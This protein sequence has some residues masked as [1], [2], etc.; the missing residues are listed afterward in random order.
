MHVPDGL[1]APPVYAAAAAIA[2]PA[3]AFAV[4]RVARTLDEAAIPRMAVLTALAFVF[5]SV[6]IPLPGGTTAHFTGVGLLTIAFGLWPAF[7]AY[8]AVLLLQVLLLGMGGITTLPITALALGLAGGGLTA[9]LH[10]LLRERR[11]PLSIVVPVAAGIVTASFLMAVVLGIQPLFGSDANGQPLYFPF[12]IAV[13]L[14]VVVVPH[15]VVGVA[16][17]ALSAAALS[18]LSRRSV[19]RA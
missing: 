3:W 14:P 1:I 13:T 7:V 6:M 9:A 12:G 15:L 19:E 4:R 2:V 17:G 18:M 10:R 5:S 8:S 11:A 16:E